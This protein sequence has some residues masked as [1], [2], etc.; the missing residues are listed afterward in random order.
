MVF[1][2][3]DN[4]NIFVVIPKSY[5][6]TPSSFTFFVSARYIFIHTKNGDDYVNGDS[7]QNQYLLDEE[8]QCL[9][10]IDFYYKLFS[11]LLSVDKQTTINVLS[12]FSMGSQQNCEKLSTR[13]MDAKWKLKVWLLVENTFS[14]P[15]GKFRSIQN[16]WSVTMKLSMILD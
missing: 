9:S 10:S 8:R 12:F 5:S 6:F 7:H 1:C 2:F 3:Y 16:F 13:K 11:F 14:N 15:A 4:E